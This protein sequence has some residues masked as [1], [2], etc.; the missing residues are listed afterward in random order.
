M[1]RLA[2]AAVVARWT[3]LMDCTTQSRE[4]T[5]LENITKRSTSTPAPMP[6]LLNRANSIS[7]P[8]IFK[9]KEKRSFRW[10]LIGQSTTNFRWFLIG[11][12]TTIYPIQ[13]VMKTPRVTDGTM[14]PVIFADAK[15][16]IGVTLISL[17]VV[18]ILMNV[19]ILDSMIACNKN[20]V[21]TGW[22][23]I[24]VRVPRA[25]TATAEKMVNVA[26]VTDPYGP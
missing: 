11:Q 4:R 24:L 8:N 20:I 1:I 17:R 6:S 18:R 16:V 13:C 26:H 22:E 7:P 25:T 15:T 9:W 12:S 10:L 23:T 19:K 5:D 3:F 21:E 2:P 14:F